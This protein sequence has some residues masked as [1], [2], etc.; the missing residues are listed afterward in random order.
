M[1]DNIEETNVQP[2]YSRREILLQSI[3]T[4]LTGGTAGNIEEL[5]PP[6]YTREEI[7][8]I[9]TLTAIE[10]GGGGGGGT[11]LIVNVPRDEQ[12]WAMD[13]TW[14]EIKNAMAAGSNVVVH[15]SDDE[16]Y[17]DEY[18]VVVGVDIYSNSY[19]VYVLLESQVLQFYA[20]SASG[21]PSYVWN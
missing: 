14:T 19:S 5:V 4:Q 21:Y 9:E 15:V 11:A 3:N 13:K 1:T 12:E 10:S 17:Q 6:P 20:E 2:P 18:G 16:N 8:L 7:L